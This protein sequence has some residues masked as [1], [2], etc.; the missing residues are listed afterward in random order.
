[1]FDRN[2]NHHL[3]SWVIPAIYAGAA[4]VAGL[5]FPRFE[6]QIFPDLVVSTSVSVANRVLLVGCLRHDCLD[7]N[8][9]LTDL[10]DGAVRRD[11]V[12]TP[13][14]AVDYS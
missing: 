4:L 2:Q 7:S 3:S 14:G 9:V 5:T 13:T 10:P 11:S 6:S 1:M 8:R 12:L